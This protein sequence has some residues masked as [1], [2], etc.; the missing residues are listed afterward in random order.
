MTLTQG[1]EGG[2]SNSD[3]DPEKSKAKRCLFG[4]SDPHY[5]HQQ[6][7]SMLRNHLQVNIPP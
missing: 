6:Y 2:Q 4:K 5:V 1:Q 3:S 7:S